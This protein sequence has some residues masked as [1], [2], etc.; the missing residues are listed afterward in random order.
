MTARVLDL[1]PAGAHIATTSALRVGA[2]YAFTLEVLGARR[3]LRGRVRWC[4]LVATRA[5]ASGDRA[6][7]YRAGIA[8]SEPQPVAATAKTGAAGSGFEPA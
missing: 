3:R 8:W 5:A 6:P 7:V 2:P 1:G 4:R